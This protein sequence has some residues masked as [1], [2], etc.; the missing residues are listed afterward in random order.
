MSITALCSLLAPPGGGS[1]QSPVLLAAAD[2][3]PNHSH[4]LAQGP[5]ISKEWSV[6]N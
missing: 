2:L 6:I 1:L 5:Q 3:A 4:L